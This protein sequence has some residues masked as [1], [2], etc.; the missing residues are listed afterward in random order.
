D[1]ERRRDL[2]EFLAR[3]DR[4]LARVGDRRAAWILRDHAAVR[5]PHPSGMAIA[6]NPVEYQS[7]PVDRLLLE[8]A[9]PIGAAEQR[10]DPAD[11]RRSGQYGH[12]SEDLFGG[13]PPRFPERL[14]LDGAK[15]EF[16]NLAERIEL[17]IG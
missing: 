12:G 8:A 11:D 15:L 6:A 3:Q 16:G 5:R 2:V 7:Q 14:D 10:L 4:H 17:G 13:L 1:A 9:R